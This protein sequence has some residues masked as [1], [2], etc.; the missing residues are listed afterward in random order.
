M[1]T[2]EILECSR[3][4]HAERE[5]V[6]CGS[7]RLTYAQLGERVDRLTSALMSLGLSQGTRVA[8]LAHNCHRYLEAYFAAAAAGTVLVPVNHRLASR[9]VAEVLVDC[10]AAALLVDPSFLGIC[11]SIRP[12]LSGLKHVIVLTDQDPDH[13]LAYEGL[14]RQAPD[15]SRRVFRNGDELLYLYYTSGTTG[16]PKGV[17]LSEDSIQFMV[18]SY[19]EY[20]NFTASDRYL[21]V[22]GLGH[23]AGLGLLLA[24][25][26]AGGCAHLDDF[27]ALR[28][29]QSLQEEGISVAALVPTMI[30]TVLNLPDA[31]RFD[32][33]ALRLLIYG[34]SPMPEALIR[35]VSEAFGVGLLQTYGMT[36]LTT[37]SFLPSHAHA[38]EGT[39]AK[40]RKLRSVG[41]PVRDIEVRLVDEFDRDV[42]RGE[43]GEVIVRGPCVM[44]GYWNQ[45]EATAAALRG[46]W[47]HTGD[48]ATMDEDGYLYLVDRKKDMIISGG[49]NVYS[50][51]VEAVLYQHPAVV[52][53]A[54]IGVP[55]SIWGETVKAL[56]V[57]KAGQITSAE[58]LQR[59][60]RERIA[61]YKVPR[62]VEFL[63][64][65]PKTA[66]GKISK[67]DL[68]APYWAAQ[69]EHGSLTHA[70]FAAN[71]PGGR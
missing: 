16:L 59:F 48:M 37:V 57:L 52:E 24:I 44:M 27:N 29:L 3:R 22:L 33:S 15:S 6:V 13:G 21:H 39:E 36:E 14:L 54:V 56:V 18:D 68:R 64:S 42:P 12:E 9:E 17:M 23:R 38:L 10:E 31:A 49:E 45:P 8:I 19:Q 41:P 11:D 70:L 4:D 62:S 67:K 2:A 53:A 34:A 26:R 32:L 1:R 5:A 65:L 25:V 69:V 43:V 46:G 60:C 66:T 51:E 28:C 58:A 61:G 47:M 55:D 20:V 7:T 71:L 40:V 63:E 35:R 30:N 50:T